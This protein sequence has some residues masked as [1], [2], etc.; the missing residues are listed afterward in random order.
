MEALDAIFPR[1]NYL[2]FHPNLF[3]G[4]NHTANQELVFVYFS[5]EI[6]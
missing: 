4:Y 6:Q 1:E 3:Y 5:Q 2:S